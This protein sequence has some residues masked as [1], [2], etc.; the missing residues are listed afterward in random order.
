MIKRT[1]Q[2]NK[3]YKLKEKEIVTKEFML[4]HNLR[5]VI[6]IKQN[7]F[8]IIMYKMINEPLPCR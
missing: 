2:M 5:A 6:L 7:R 3:K 4:K 1:S 8:F